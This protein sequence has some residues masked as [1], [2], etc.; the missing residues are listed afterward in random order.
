MYG[1]GLPLTNGEQLSDDTGTGIENNPRIHFNAN[2]VG[3]V[4]YFDVTDL[5]PGRELQLSDIKFRYNT[6]GK[7][8]HDAEDMLRG[9]AGWRF[10]WGYILQVIGDLNPKT[11]ERDSKK[12]RRIGFEFRKEWESATS[13]ND[14]SNAIIIYVEADDIVKSNEFYWIR[15]PKEVLID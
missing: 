9:N 1:S 4:Q 2:V 15:G 14:I 13:T 5:P 8:T 12:Y 6:P 10:G 11:V 3:V 7:R